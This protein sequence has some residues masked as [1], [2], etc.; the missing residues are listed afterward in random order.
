[1]GNEYKVAFATGSRADYGIVRKYIS[2]LNE[3]PSIDFS[4]LATGALLDEKFGNAKTIVEE[5]GFR[6]AFECKVDNKSEK[7]SDTTNIMAFVLQE[8]GKFFEENKY[9]LLLILGDRYEIYSV[10]IAAA[11]NRIPILHMHG[12]E[13]TLA[14][15]D[16]F[17]RHSITKM[18]RFHFTST[19]EYRKRII[20][21]G[22]NP[23]NVYYL[24]ALGAENCKYIDMNHVDKRLI[25]LPE[26][27]IF[28][29]LFHPETL[30]TQ[31]PL[32]Q[33][34]E[35]LRAVNNYIDN[36]Q[37]IF[38]GSNADT[39]SDVISNRVQE[40]CKEKSN[41]HFYVNLHPDSYHYLVKKSLALIGN[42]S[43]GIIEVPSLNSFTINIGN[44]QAGRV[45]GNSVVDVICKYEDIDNAI[46]DIIKIGNC[47]KIENPYYK[48]NS[49]ALYYQTTKKILTQVRNLKYKKFYDICYPK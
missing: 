25:E 31:S 17:I 1:M 42:S 39:A 43:S 8:F 26:K 35:L 22:E 34:N 36:F 7:L 40:Y 30:N 23:E 12:G 16:E 13:I 14:N 5:D 3:D 37:F 4:I 32:E 19:E 2:M 28:T 45:R 21:M 18:A 49:A 41:A 11:M 47:I 10:A 6:I 24:G 29:V 27:K 46:A 44:R 9:D 38:I 15:Y 48:E 20:Q 33:I